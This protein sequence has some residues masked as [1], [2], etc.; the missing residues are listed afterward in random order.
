[1]DLRPSFLWKDRPVVNLARESPR[2]G[3]RV[4]A[5]RLPSLAQDN[6]PLRGTLFE[7]YELCCLH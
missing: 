5:L 2:A 4:S 1:M 6:A 7:G 3:L